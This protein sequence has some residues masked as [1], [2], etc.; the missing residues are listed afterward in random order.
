[1]RPVEPVVDV[2]HVSDWDVES[3]ALFCR[4]SRLSRSHFANNSDFHIRSIPK[5]LTEGV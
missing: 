3:F 5:T 2:I 4:E 1:M